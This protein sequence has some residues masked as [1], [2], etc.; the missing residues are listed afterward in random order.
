VI[1]LGRNYEYSVV[2]DPKREYLWVLSRTPEFPE[3]T[4]QRIL[5]RVQ[6][7]GFDPGKLVKTNQRSRPAGPGR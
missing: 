3:P 2:C 7:L 5:R 4:Y 1:D 6:E